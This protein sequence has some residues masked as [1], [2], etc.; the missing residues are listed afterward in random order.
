MGPLCAKVKMHSG[1]F[2]GQVRTKKGCGAFMGWKNLVGQALFDL[3]SKPSSPGKSK[4]SLIYM[5][6]SSCLVRDL[7]V[8][9]QLLLTEFLAAFSE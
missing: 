4:N 2:M 7:R 5:M 9:R 1:T 3:Y 6:H 8:C